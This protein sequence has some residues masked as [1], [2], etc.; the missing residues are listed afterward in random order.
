MSRLPL[1]ATA[2]VLIA[3]TGCLIRGDD[4]DG[5]PCVRWSAAYRPLLVGDTA[6]LEVGRVRGSDCAPAHLPVRATWRTTDT[7]VV[8][9]SPDGLLTGVAPG[10]FEVHAPEDTALLRT[11]GFVLPSGWRAQIT[12]D[13][14]V[15]SVGDSVTFEMRAFD[16]SGRLLPPVPYSLYTPEFEERP[17]DSA[18]RRVEPLLTK[19]SEQHVVGPATFVARQA[20]RTQLRGQLASARDTVSLIIDP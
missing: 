2:L 20:G 11:D 8:R 5:R 17:T 6:R 19:W 13:S 12:P 16:A 10:R 1:S 15:V 3:V 4:G 7:G 14:A 9:I 18:G